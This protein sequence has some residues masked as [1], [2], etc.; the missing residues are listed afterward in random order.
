MTFFFLAPFPVLRSVA[1]SGM[2]EGGK[3]V[4]V[5]IGGGLWFSVRRAAVLGQLVAGG[6]V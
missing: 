3:A 5:V 4:S 6:M 1:P 2:V